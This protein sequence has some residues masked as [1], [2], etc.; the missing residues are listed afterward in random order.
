MTL[1][2]EQAME[3]FDLEDAARALDGAANYRVLRRFRPRSNYT[4]NAPLRSDLSLGLYIDTETTSLDTE[5]AKII[6]LAIVPFLFDRRFGQVWSVLPGESWL[7]DPGELI[8]PVVTE[9]TGI[10]DD[11]VR[12]QSIDT[13]RILEL[14]EGSIDRIVIAHNAEYDRPVLERAIPAFVGVD[15]ACSYREVPWKRFGASS[16]KLGHILADCCRE[17]HD[18]HRALDDA[19]VGVHVL[20]ATSLDGRTALSWLLES[21]A[22]TTVRLWAISAPYEARGKLKARGYKWSDG[23]RGRPKA[24]HR[25][26][27]AED[28]A[29]E[30]EW[31]RH[32]AYASPRSSL[33]IA[34]NRYS[35]RA[36]R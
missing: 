34:R 9:V 28:E 30:S 20:A 15:W 3:E 23:S 5:T 12:G 14:V 22:R 2:V 6:E 1:S 19:L 13:A 31:L 7:N 8:D 32:Y 10:T 25:E 16:G 27:A 29:A 21:S 4:G 36:D 11:M 17:F 18:A 26:I 35:V 33:L 24:W